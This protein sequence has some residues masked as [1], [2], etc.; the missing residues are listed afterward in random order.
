[1]K[2]IQQ[3]V[4]SCV[5]SFY[6]ILYL[7]TFE[8][9]DSDRMIEQLLDGRT[10]W[11]WNLSR[12]LVRFDTKMP[13]TE[14]RDLAGAL[15]NWLDQELSSHFLIVKDAH[16]ALRDNP[17]AIT[18]L[19][20]LAHRIA[21]DDITVAS[22]FL[23]APMLY[24]PPELEKFT[25]VFEWEPPDEEEIREIV[26]DRAQELGTKIHPDVTARLAV[27]CRGLSRYEIER[28]LNRGYQKDGTIGNDDVELVKTEKR[29]IVRKS[30]ILEMVLEGD[31]S[32]ETLRGLEG[33]KAWLGQKAEI[34]K[35]LPEA[36]AF[37]VDEPKGAMVV[38]FPGCGKSLAAKATAALFDLPLLRLDIGSV[39]GR[40]VG[41]SEANMRKALKLAEAVSP[42]VLWVDEVEKAFA[43]VKGSDSGSEIAKRLFGYFLTW[44]QEKTHPVFI[45]ATANDMSHLPPEFLR[46]GRLDEIFFVDLP[47]EEERLEILNVHLKKRGKQEDGVDVRKVADSTEG[48]SGA[49][50]ESVVKDAIERAFVDDKRSLTTDLLLVSVKET[51]PLAKMMGDDLEKGRKIYKEKGIKDA[52]SSPVKSSQTS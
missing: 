8:E 21:H 41:D 15:E 19:K 50:L 24:V 13:M 52:S 35:N 30:G 25:T 34:M 23:V 17:V 5:E 48:F 3:A 33:L 37:G 6:P 18:R 12:G 20:A 10:A 44:M 26:H 38:G 40:Y 36:R 43:G 4:R 29:Q 31:K 7:I 28:L 16:L 39:M 42:C 45:L 49:D 51:F 2:D 32:L 11:E 9:E 46:K 27:A 47:N 14:Y 1:M 22:I